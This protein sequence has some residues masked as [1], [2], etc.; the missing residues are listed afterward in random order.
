MMNIINNFSRYHS[1]L[2]LPGSLIAGVV[3]YAVM[4]IFFIPIRIT[5]PEAIIVSILVFGLTKYYGIPNAMELKVKNR[6]G[7]GSYQNND[8]S[9]HYGIDDSNNI[10]ITEILFVS[11]YVILLL[12]VSFFPHSNL[13]LYISWN[14]LSLISLIQLGAAV[15]L[16]F[17]FPGYAVISALDK[18]HK[19][20]PLLRG[21]LAYI[22]SMFF[23]GFTGYLLAS[24]GF[25][26][27]D[28]SSIL[29]VIYALALLPFIAVLFWRVSLIRKKFIY[30]SVSQTVKIQVS[31]FF[32]KM[33]QR[34]SLLLIFASLFT[35][36]ILS[37]YSLY[38][39]IIIGDQWFHHGR[40][41]TFIYGSYSDFAASGVEYIYPPFLSA[42][43]AV[44]FTLS[45]N[46]PSVNAYASIGFLNIVPVLA[47]YY[48]FTSWISGP[49]V[50]KAAILASALFLLSAG[51]GW[52]YALDIAL[53]QPLTS[54]LS[55]LQTLYTASK[56]TF[57]I[58][59]P[60]TFIL[61]SHPEVTTG[62]QLIVLPIGFV[63][64]GLI[65][66]VSRSRQIKFCAIVFVITTF[67]PTTSFQT[68]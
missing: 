67:N 41:L 35:L 24:L 23:S 63:L 43:L 12:I 39:G 58:R 22:F 10:P 64:L 18:S 40:A 56:Q 15:A 4:S 45:G 21:L 68:A 1:L 61:V 34:I 2:A 26:L 30:T 9:I 37:T 32:R 48:F 3:T 51:F 49:H 31:R 5:V 55:A 17:F 14:E 7:I 54:Q 27:S 16:C 28:M 46:T 8:N 66:E 59:S 62:V 60:S 29:I 6:R 13:V 50:R 42:L 38:G 65:K 19:L 52:V 44:F 47:F 25:P 36:V 20:R 57:D 33:N 53:N 11:I